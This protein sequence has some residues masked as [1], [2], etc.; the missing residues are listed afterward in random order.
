V[1][2]HQTGVGFKYVAPKMIET[3]AMIGGEESGGYAFRGNVPERDGI[4]AGLYILDM[5]V[6]LKRKPSELIEYLF[7]KVGG[8]YYDRIDRRFSGDRQNREQ[9]ILSANPL[10]IGGLKVVGLNKMDGFK[11][12]LEDGGWLLIRF[13]GTEPIMRVYTETTHQDRVQP[14]LQDG[15]RIAGLE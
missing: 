14:I 11:F 15:L 10:T 5:M 3:D 13:S 8:H 9:R 1:P 2:V 4:L 12:D 6:K 7:S